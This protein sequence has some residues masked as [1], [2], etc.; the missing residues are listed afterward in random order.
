MKNV[1][2]WWSNMPIYAER[3]R[4]MIYEFLHKT[5]KYAKYFSD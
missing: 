2:K 5:G 4:L 3:V 1:S